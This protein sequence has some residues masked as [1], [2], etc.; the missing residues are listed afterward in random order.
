MTR[1]GNEV[2]RQFCGRLDR[3][4]KQ[5]ATYS[6]VLVNTTVEK[7]TYTPTFTLP[8]YAVILQDDDHNEMEYVV[9]ALLKSVPGLTKNQARRIM[10]EAHN[11]GR[12]VV[13]ICPLEQAEY[14]R[15]RIR[16]FNLSVTI[17]KA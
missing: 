11:T 16:S 6:K 9:T 8:P 7:E 5:L 3:R 17:E 12:S 1:I 10:L 15:D 2:G 14:F 13:I 4:E